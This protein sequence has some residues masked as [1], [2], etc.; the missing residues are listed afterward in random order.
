MKELKG[1]QL[2]PIQLIVEEEFHR[3]APGGMGS[4]KCAGNY[5]QV[6]S[7]HFRSLSKLNRF[8]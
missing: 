7:I 4:T 3:A 2:K 8:C 6:F 1:G 5:S